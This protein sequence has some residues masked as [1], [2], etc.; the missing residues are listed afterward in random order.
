MNSTCNILFTA[1]LLS[2]ANVWAQPYGYLSPAKAVSSGPAET[3][4]DT[5][6]AS[7]P[8][9]ESNV[10]AAELEEAMQNIAEELSATL[11]IPEGLQGRVQQGVLP[12]IFSRNAR[13][14]VAQ[15]PGD[16]NA[17]PARNRGRGRGLPANARLRSSATQSGS[18]QTSSSNAIGGFV[19]NAFLFDT[20]GDGQ[21]AAHEMSSLFQVLTTTM[22]AD[23]TGQSLSGTGSSRPN[24]VD[25]QLMQSQSVREAQSLFLQLGM[26]FD[27][28]ADGQLNQTEIRTMGACLSQNNNS[29]I[30]AALQN[31][32]S[33][34][35]VLPQQVVP[36]VEPAVTPDVVPQ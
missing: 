11:A 21:L 8:K 36:L 4:A 12:D 26:S 7:G 9:T 32:P 33:V 5:N 25:F 2:T 1:V 3:V 30:D 34:V 6:M 10:S 28:N 31:N 27:N 17:M 35:P 13:P 16:P 14:Q 15:V 20:N 22:N 24:A 29:L 23:R 19:D 18:R